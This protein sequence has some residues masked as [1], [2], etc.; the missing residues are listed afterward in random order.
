MSDYKDPVPDFS[1]D[2]GISCARNGFI[3]H[4]YVEGT[5]MIFGKVD[6]IATYIFNQ[7]ER[8]KNTK[9]HE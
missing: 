6:E 7:E 2:Y 8:R 9:H 4:D 1:L 3:V 5:V